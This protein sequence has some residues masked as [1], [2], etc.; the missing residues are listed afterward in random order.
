M[1]TRICFLFIPA[2][3]MT[4]GTSSALELGSQRFQEYSAG[5]PDYATMVGMGHDPRISSNFYFSDQGFVRAMRTYPFPEGAGHRA[6]VANMMNFQS[7]F[8]MAGAK[9]DPRSVGFISNSMGRLLSD[10]QAEVELIEGINAS[11]LDAE[12]AGDN[13]KRY[14]AAEI[15]TP[16]PGY[17]QTADNEQAF[18]S[19]YDNLLLGRAEEALY[20]GDEISGQA[21]FTRRAIDYQNTDEKQFSAGNFQRDALLRSKKTAETFRDFFQMKAGISQRNLSLMPTSESLVGGC[22]TNTPSNEDQ[23]DVFNR[24]IPQEEISFYNFRPPNYN[25]DFCDEYVASE[26]EYLIK[27]QPVHGQLDKLVQDS[28]QMAEGLNKMAQD[29]SNKNLTTAE[30][31]NILNTNSAWKTLSERAK[32]YK[33]CEKKDCLSKAEKALLKMVEYP[34]AENHR[35]EEAN[36]IRRTLLQVIENKSLGSNSLPKIALSANPNQGKV[37]NPFGLKLDK[38]KL[39]K[40]GLDNDK[41]KAPDENNE[42]KD[43]EPEIK[44]ID[45]QKYMAYH[46][47]R[48]P[49]AN[50]YFRGEDGILRNPFGFPVTEFVHPKHLNIFSIISRRYQLKFYEEKKILKKTTK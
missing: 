37:E 34:G 43:N 48:Y 44:V 46:G 45:G 28:T 15:V 7:N 25:F 35:S 10:P 26:Q 3:I 50:G 1:K 42:S 22:K 23:Y 41:A 21:Y 19:A 47:K 36:E 9:T 27:N 24:G 40:N 2:L 17:F 14:I 18:N 4:S 32:A 16:T 20:R 49:R 38:H 8:V 31:A 12:Q 33:E 29:L 5:T 13:A 30:I 11:R 6:W 39:G